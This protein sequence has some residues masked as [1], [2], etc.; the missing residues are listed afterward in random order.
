MWTTNGE[1]LTRKLSTFVLSRNGAQTVLESCLVDTMYLM[2]TLNNEW[3]DKLTPEQYK[4]LREAGTEAPFSGAYV[5]HFEDGRYACAG[6][7]TE[8]FGSEDKF[9]SHCGWP[10]FS[11]VIDKGT[12]ELVDDDSLGMHRV[13]VRCKQ[14]GGHLGHVFDDGPRDR[15]GK[16][17][18]INSTA[19]N[20]HS[21]DNESN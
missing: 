10:S 9:D 13:E 8:L 7:G 15:G 17:F 12:I 14:C 19:L 4:V 5:D 3:K 6:C 2:T 1:I 11:D 16:R 21:R 20:F 18:C